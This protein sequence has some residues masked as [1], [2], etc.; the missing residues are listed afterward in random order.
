MQKQKLKACLLAIAVLACISF[1]QNQLALLGT[2]TAPNG[3]EVY[4]INLD[5]KDTLD[6]TTVSDNKFSFTVQLSRPVY[7]FVGH[8][9]DRVRFIMEPGTL[10]VNLDERTFKGT[11][12]A[13]AYNDFHKRFYGY[14]MQRNKERKALTANKETITSAEFNE[15]WSQLDDKYRNLQGELTDSLVRLNKDNLLGAIALDDLALVDTTKFMQLYGMM[16]QEMQSFYML[17][18]DVKNI[19]LQSRTAPGK[20]FTDYLIKRGNLDGSDVSL[21]DYVGKGKYILLDHWAS[22]CGP[23]KAEMPYIKKVWEDFVGEYFDVVSIAVND[24]RENTLRAL[25]SLDMPWHQ[26]VDAQ[27]I[28]LFSY[29]INAI[30]HLIL[31]APDGT[32]LKRGLRGEQIYTTI[33]QLLSDKAL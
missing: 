31:F 17:K 5:N 6:V 2:Y 1:S 19:A 11:P 14:N 10:M 29:N 26:I 18:N 30:P 25:Q 7:A 12:M 28:P 33:Q 27:K 20:M 23:C 4:L 13:D 22:W 3:T 8:D 21:S 16:S 9:R 15:R 32:I 24:K